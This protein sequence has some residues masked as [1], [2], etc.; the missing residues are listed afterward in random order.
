[1]PD[2][3]AGPE[4]T[5]VPAGARMSVRV[6]PRAPRDGIEGVRHGRLVVRL[7][8]P[9]VEGA[10]NDAALRIIAKALGVP[11]SAVRLVTGETAR[12]KVLEVAGLRAADVRARLAVWTGAPAG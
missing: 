7:T 6:M 8:A 11:R 10:A 9:P 5:D 1:M 4:V 3:A 2:E 12:N